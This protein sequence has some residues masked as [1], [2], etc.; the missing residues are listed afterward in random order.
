MKIPRRQ[1]EVTIPSVAMGDIAFLLLIFLF[2][3]ARANDTS[4][5]RW[6]PAKVTKV[7]PA[8]S[9]AAE[10]ALDANH[11]LFLN[12]RETGSSQLGEQ[13][14]RILGERPAGQRSVHLKVDRSVKAQHFEP[15]IEAISLAGGEMV[16]ILEEDKDSNSK[17][18]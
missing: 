4:H 1:M 5:I 2:I 3:L 18:P 13:L 7:S 6:Q 12:G 8:V 10:V 17:K 16:H 11:R 9:A 14:K 15:A